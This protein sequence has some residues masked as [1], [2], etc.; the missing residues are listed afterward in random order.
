M[1]DISRKTS[2]IIHNN[3]N[4]LIF[5]YNVMISRHSHFVAR[6]SNG[7]NVFVEKVKKTLS[8]QE[9]LKTIS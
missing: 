2:F 1:V 3:R 5:L 8:N 9:S 6:R 4:S 7:T